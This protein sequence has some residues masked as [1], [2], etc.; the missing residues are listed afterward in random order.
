[1]RTI[2]PCRVNKGLTSKFPEGLT[3]SKDT[4][5]RLQAK[6]P[7]CFDRN[8]D[9]EISP[10]VNNVNNFNSWSQKF[11]QKNSGSFINSWLFFKNGSKEETQIIL[12]N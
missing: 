10:T 11:T 8:K 7:K 12:L 1:M 3:K 5:R 4:W 2:Y 9:K 6:Q